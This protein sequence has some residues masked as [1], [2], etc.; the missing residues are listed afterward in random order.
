MY[1]QIKV[2][3]ACF[4]LLLIGALPGC[5]E[6][7]TRALPGSTGK[8][9]EV[10]L[11]MDTKSWNGNLGESIKNTLAREQ[12]A[13][14]QPEPIF[15]VVHIPISSFKGLFITHRNIVIFTIGEHGPNEITE[16]KN[17]W[18]TSQ[19]VVRVSANTEAECLD[20]LAVVHMRAGAKINKFTVPR[21]GSPGFDQAVL[22]TTTC[23]SRKMRKRTPRATL[24]FSP[25]RIS[26]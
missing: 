2:F 5:D 18:A 15:N 14:P 22:S 21:T 4:C 9:G 13:L 16:E 24:E 3:S 8:A 12:E 6:E 1:P 7:S 17:L 23:S 10:I 20:L 11:V 26:K 19:V 25:V